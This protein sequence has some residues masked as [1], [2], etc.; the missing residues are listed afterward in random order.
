MNNV[1]N[2][3]LGK[4]RK[5]RREFV[6]ARKHHLA[7][8]DGINFIICEDDTCKQK[9]SIHIN[10]D[11]IF[12]R[13]DLYALNNPM[14]EFEAYKVHSLTKSMIEDAKNKDGYDKSKN[15]SIKKLAVEQAKNET[16]AKFGEKEYFSIL[17][18]ERAKKVKQE[19]KQVKKVIKSVKEAKE[20]VLPE[21]LD[22]G[23]DEVIVKQVN[24]SIKIN[25]DF[26]N[27]IEELKNEFDKDEVSIPNV[28]VKVDVVGG[29]PQEM[30]FDLG[31]DE[32]ELQVENLIEEN[33]NIDEFLGDSDL[34]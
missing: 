24:E 3:L 30:P 18:E 32:E 26:K 15:N 4:Q 20:G 19:K 6:G 14:V 33:F 31:L 12:I 16:I 21:A 34:F 27:Q 13:H 1:L 23:I 5:S 2:E 22:T 28:E 10:E 8:Y 29:E 17:G 7:T 9:Y 11:I 25:E